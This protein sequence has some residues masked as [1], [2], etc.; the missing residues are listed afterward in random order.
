MALPVLAGDEAM[1]VV[2]Q[3]AKMNPGLSAVIDALGKEIL[4]LPGVGLRNGLAGASRTYEIAFVRSNP[5]LAFA[6]F[7]APSYCGKWMPGEQYA[8]R[9]S[10]EVR[11]RGVPPPNSDGW[12]HGRT[13]GGD[14]WHTGHVKEDGSMLGVAI[15]RVK[16][17]Y[18]SCG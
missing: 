10:V 6:T 17:A 13:F 4:Q 7:K 9:L 5:S 8:D 2:K 12:L 18:H 11:F 16:E 15:E 14:E 1:S 3:L